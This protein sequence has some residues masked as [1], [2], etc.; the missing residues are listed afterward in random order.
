VFLP[1]VEEANQDLKSFGL[2]IQHETD[3][4]IGLGLH[5]RVLT[6]GT[7]QPTSTRRSLTMKVSD[8][9]VV[10]FRD[11]G[12]GQSLGPI[13][14]IDQTSVESILTELLHAVG[15]DEGRGDLR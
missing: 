14:V 1:V 3:Q 6:L 11:R 2:A 9:Q 7:L 15:Y 10:V 12:P 13:E 8:G 4:G 5:L